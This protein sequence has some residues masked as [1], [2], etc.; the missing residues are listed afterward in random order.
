M[1][2]RRIILEN[3][4][5]M[6]ATWWVRRG[7][8]PPPLAI[9]PDVGVIVEEACIPISCFFL[10]LISNA[11]VAVMEWEGSNP[12]CQSPFKRVRALHMATDFFED[13]AAKNEITFLFS[14][15]IPGRGDG[16]LFSARGWTKPQGEPHEM[17]SFVT[18]NKKEAVCH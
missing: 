15:T 6:L 1:R 7:G 4:Y 3:D 2:V 12:D 5:E 14:W 16:R 10:Y 13:Y 8:T 11:P 9:L 18:E 17:W